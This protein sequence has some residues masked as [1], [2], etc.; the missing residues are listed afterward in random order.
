[1]LMVVAIPFREG[2]NEAEHL[3]QRF[4]VGIEL[5][6]VSTSL[7]WCMKPLR[8]HE[9]LFEA[10][11]SQPVS[12]AWESRSVVAPNPVCHRPMAMEAMGISLQRI[13]WEP[14]LL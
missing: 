4:P 7:R 3:R 2:S 10:L 8:I 11:I 1:M 14:L 12:S 5:N 6:L 13:S 9:G